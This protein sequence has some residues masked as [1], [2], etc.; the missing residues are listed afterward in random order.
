MKI[1]KTTITFVVL[2]EYDDPLPSRMSLEDL[3]AACDTGNM[4]GNHTVSKEEVLTD[5]EEI[6]AEL[7]DMGNDGE[8]FIDDES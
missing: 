1:R 5:P 8:F 4:I 7:I 2:S 3:A 6:K